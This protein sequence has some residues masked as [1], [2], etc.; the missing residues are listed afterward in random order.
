LKIK[1]SIIIVNYNGENI[2]TDCLKSII[3]HKTKYPY[4]IILVDN[5]SQDGSKEKIKAFSAHLQLIENSKNFGF[6]KAN[7]QGAALA[8]GEYLFLLN[9]D[10]VL[11]ENVLDGLVDYL[12]QNPQVGA[13]SPKLLNQDKTLQ[14]QGSIL[15]KWQFTGH[16]PRNINFISGAAFFTRA[17][18]YKKLDGLDETFFFYNEDIDICK[19]IKKAGFKIAYLPGLEIIHYG[20]I[21]TKTRKAE[22]IIEGYRG[23]LYL[24]Y[25]HYGLIVYIIYKY[26]F[27]L[28]L[29]INFLF[30]PKI[31]KLNILNDVLNYKITK[32]HEKN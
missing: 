31:K 8:K 21:S 20:G 26:I 7:N 5:N 28:Y 29:F 14:Y 24:V 4:E 30:W 16:K 10:T 1:T 2:I 6:A 27:L 3:N 13:A 23:G 17:S 19:R 12:E 32:K 15:G 9:N 22:S 11:L 25:K 18:L